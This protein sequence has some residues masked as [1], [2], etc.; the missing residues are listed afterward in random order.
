[1]FGRAIAIDERAA[2]IWIDRSV[3]V[4]NQ[5]EHEFGVIIEVDAE[6]IPPDLVFAQLI[7]AELV[8]H[9][10][11][12]TDIFLFAVNRQLA[13]GLHAGQRII[14]RRSSLA[15]CFLAMPIIS[16]KGRRLERSER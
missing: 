12:T 7:A 4:P 8:V 11:Y 15:L 3:F 10:R 14:I 6:P 1:M 9:P 13:F 5:I 16:V 2:G